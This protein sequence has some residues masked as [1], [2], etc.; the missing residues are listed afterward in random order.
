[1][2]EPSKIILHYARDSLTVCEII[3]L[4]DTYF[5]NI[6]GTKKLTGPKDAGD[7]L[8]SIPD[9]IRRNPSMVVLA[10]SFIKYL[11]LQV[12]NTRKNKHSEAIELE[13]SHIFGKNANQWLYQITKNSSKDENV[14]NCFAVEIS[15]L[16]ELQSLLR[17]SKI[18]PEIIFLDPVTR[19]SALK[20]CKK[21]VLFIHFIKNAMILSLGTKSRT[22]VKIVPFKLNEMLKKI[23]PD[24]TNPT[25]SEDL[26]LAL[27]SPKESLKLDK[28]AKLIEGISDEI[29]IYL[30]EELKKFL[31]E[32]SSS[33]NESRP[34]FLVL[35]DQ[36]MDFIGMP[37]LANIIEYEKIHSIDEILKIQLSSAIH[38]NQA[39]DEILP[40]LIGATNISPKKNNGLRFPKNINKMEYIRNYWSMWAHES[41]IPMILFISSLLLTY[42]IILKKNITLK[43]TNIYLSATNT[44]FSELKKAISAAA[45]IFAEKKKVAQSVDF[46]KAHQD[47]LLEFF[48]GLQMAVDDA[49][50]TWLDSLE[51]DYTTAE[52]NKESNYSN[53]LVK[54][55]GKMFVEIM[56]NLPRFTRIPQ[57]RF[58][59]LLEKIRQIS[60]VHTIQKIKVK[61]P[62][63]HLLTFRCNII[64]DRKSS[65]FDT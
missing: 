17:D 4:G 32:F 63:N 18:Y 7:I 8:G 49:N 51:L 25:S 41:I 28:D 20:K 38:G 31:A 22:K 52:Q 58:D 1:M 11:P 56:S 53:R 12:Y 27:F 37:K 35:A 19:L 44:K 5:I 26:E 39:I 16:N 50:E 13:F 57:K 6:I 60:H 23:K 29:S 47:A 9:K 2:K 55:S 33:E 65:I 64:L 36:P 46:I 40:A 42:A 43:N 34:D 24:P 10:D 15:M 62:E 3:C 45:K 14:L 54:I 48:D 59:I 21:N 30:E 61:N